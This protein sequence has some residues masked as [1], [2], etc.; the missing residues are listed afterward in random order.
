MGESKGLGTENTQPAIRQPAARGNNYLITIGIDK[1]RNGFRQLPSCRQDC[2]DLAGVLTGSYGFTVFRG[3]FPSADPTAPTLSDE[4]ATL[5]NI[6]R[7]FRTLDTH[8][9]FSEAAKDGSS[10]LHNLIIYF[11]G[12]GDVDKDRKFYWAPVDFPSDPTVTRYYNLYSITDELLRAARSIRFRHL[13]IVM[14][15]CYS[16]ATF[17]DSHFFKLELTVPDN[18]LREEQPSC[19]AICSSAVNQE[20][21]AEQDNSLMTRYLLDILRTNKDRRLTVENLITTLQTYFLDEETRTGQAAPQQV[22]GQKLLLQAGNTGVFSLYR[23]TEGQ[24]AVIAKRIGRKLVLM[25]PELNYTTERQKIKQLKASKKNTFVLISAIKPR[26][27]QLLLRILLEKLSATHPAVMP[28]DPAALLLGDQPT[29]IALEIYRSAD[30]GAFTKEEELVPLLLEKLRCGHV[31]IK[32]VISDALFPKDEV[33]REIGRIAN[34]VQELEATE[35]YVYLFA[36]DY[37]EAPY[38]TV[39]QETPRQLFLHLNDIQDV[40]ED[41]FTDWYDLQ[42]KVLEEEET[43][44]FFKARI[45]EGRKVILGEAIRQPGTVIQNICQLVDCPE[46]AVEILKE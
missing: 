26:A 30:V 27:P 32:L 31:A 5:A 24:L 46:V 19:W 2:I 7:L 15:S 21:L 14:D 22:F 42:Y 18:V 45:E 38:A 36:M 29:N 40:D 35:H 37:G 1:Y 13:L 4:T 8:P 43:K 11:S 44:A 3:P 28:V 39:F 9:E 20:S 12:H 10:I 6:T 25:L 34:R 33:I 23:T 41:T 17:T 16:A